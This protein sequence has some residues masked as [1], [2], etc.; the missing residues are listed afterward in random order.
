M[1]HQTKN[2]QET[3][4]ISIRSWLI[5]ILLAAILATNVLMLLRIYNLPSSFPTFGTLRNSRTMTRDERIKLLDSVPLVRVQGGH[6][7]AD[8]R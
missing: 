3:F 2:F 7:D 6:V 8:I 5:V 4:H 1:T